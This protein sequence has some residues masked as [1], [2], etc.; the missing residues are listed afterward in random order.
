MSWSCAEGFEY[1]LGG[2]CLRLTS[3]LLR[4]QPPRCWFYRWLCT[5]G[6]SVPL[7]GARCLGIFRLL[8]AKKGAFC[9]RWLIFLL[10]SLQSQELLPALDCSAGFRVSFELLC[11]WHLPA[12]PVLSPRALVVL[13]SDLPYNCKSWSFC[14]YGCTHSL[15]S[16]SPSLDPW[17]LTRTLASLD[18]LLQVF[19][20]FSPR[21]FVLSPFL[22]GTL[23]V[24]FSAFHLLLLS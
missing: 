13:I 17:V 21:A 14:I 24:I 22:P 10:A 15:V 12:Y 20:S 1:L 2:H 16:W 19:F 8:L 4:P 23:L 9:V 3:N 18:L 11:R 6:A 7:S 5:C